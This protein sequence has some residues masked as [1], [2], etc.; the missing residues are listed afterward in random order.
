MPTPQSPSN[1]CKT[2]IEGFDDILNGGLPRDR[3]YLILGEPGVGKTTLALQFLLEGIRQGEKA[4]YITLS[5]T[6]AELN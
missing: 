1:L 2:G 3:L 4:L 5:E 6:K